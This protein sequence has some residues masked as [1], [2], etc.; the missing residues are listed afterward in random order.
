MGH[1]LHFDGDSGGI[2]WCLEGDASS[3]QSRRHPGI[4][5]NRITV[6]QSRYVALHVGIFWCIGTFRIRDGDPVDIMVAD[7]GMYDRLACGKRQEDGFAAGRIRHINILAG[8]RGLALSY[9]RVKTSR[10][11]LLLKAPAGSASADTP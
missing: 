9:H 8:H 7:A 11:T 4:Y 1:I 6:E 10:A 5:Q 2:A 3:R